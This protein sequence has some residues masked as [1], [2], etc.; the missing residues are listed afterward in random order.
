[1]QPP[2]R[3]GEQTRQGEISGR[4]IVVLV[5]SMALGLMAMFSLLGYFYST[6][7]PLQY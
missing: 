6:H 2:S 7:S 4:I 5:V 3:T 1:M